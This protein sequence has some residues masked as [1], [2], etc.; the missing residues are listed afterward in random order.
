MKTT[1]F[2]EPGAMVVE[3]NT[4]WAIDTSGWLAPHRKSEF[5]NLPGNHRQIQVRVIASEKQR[6]IEIGHGLRADMLDAALTVSAEAVEA[7]AVLGLVD[8]VNQTGA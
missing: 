6:T 1:G 4:A 3:M 2:R 5:A 7:Q 8:F